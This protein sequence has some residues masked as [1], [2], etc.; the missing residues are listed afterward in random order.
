MDAIDAV[1]NEQYIQRQEGLSYSDGVLIYI[2]D[3]EHIFNN[4]LEAYLRSMADEKITRTTLVFFSSSKN[5][6]NF[7]LPRSTRKHQSNKR[8]KSN[9]H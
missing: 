3:R 1:L 5:K 8:T 4:Q 6:K 2:V 7:L 9:H